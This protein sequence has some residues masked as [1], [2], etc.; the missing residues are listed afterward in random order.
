[1]FKCHLECVLVGTVPKS[2]YHGGER[3][4]GEDPPPGVQ[5]HSF[6]IQIFR[7]VAAS[8]AGPPPRW[9]ILDTP[10]LPLFLHDQH[11]ICSDKCFLNDSTC[12]NLLRTVLQLFVHT[13]T[14]LYILNRVLL[15]CD[16]NM[17]SEV[18]VSEGRKFVSITCEHY[19]LI[20]N[21]HVR[22]QSVWPW[23]RWILF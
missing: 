22:Q 4:P 2:L 6:D 23:P 18:N 11:I 13:T 17:I 15:F 10:L 21:V 19:E 16:T 3:C 5:I 7:N 9:E 20:I 1:M 8:G 14:S 12:L